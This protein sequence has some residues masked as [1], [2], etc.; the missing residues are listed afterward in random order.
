[1]IINLMFLCL[2]LVYLRKAWLLYGIFFSVGHLGMKFLI[3][4]F[5]N[6]IAFKKRASRIQTSDVDIPSKSASG[7]MSIYA[8]IIRALK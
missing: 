4:F 3:A 8:T 7:F 1:M 2:S 6:M 5:F